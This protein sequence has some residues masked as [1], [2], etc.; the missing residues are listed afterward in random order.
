MQRYRI[1]HDTIYRYDAQVWLSTHT[2]RLR[3]REGHELRIETSSLRI[4]PA[5]TLRWHRDAENNSVAIASF[6]EPTDSLIIESDTVIQQYHQAPLD[7]LVDPEA[8]FFPFHYGSEEQ[9]LLPPYRRPVD[10][11]GTLEVWVAGLYAPGEHLET[12]SLLDRIS[13]SIHRRRCTCQERVGRGSTPPRAP[14]PGPTTSPWPCPT[15]RM[16]CRRWLDP[17]ADRHDPF[18]V[19]V[20]G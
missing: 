18:C 8:Q 4:T 12:Y 16:R 15:G 17:S 20:F 14:W 19:W 11:D 5:A 2:L 6:N 1:R 3:P 9:L 10:H 7:F 13:S